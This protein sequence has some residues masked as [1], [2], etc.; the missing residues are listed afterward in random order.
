MTGKKK[1]IFFTLST[2]AVYR[3]LLFFPGSVYDRL[4]RIV[5]ERDDLCIVFLVPEKDF[6]KYAVLFGEDIADRMLLQ[7]VSV[8]YPRTFLEKAFYFFY[9]YLIYTGTTKQLATL[10]VRPEEP[11]AGGVL[12]QYLAPVKFL[13]ANTF[14]RW[15]TLREYIVP[16]LYL[17]IFRSRPFLELFSKYNPDLVFISHLYGRLDTELLAEAKRQRTPAIGMVANWDHLDKYYLPFKT[18]KLLVQSEQLKNFAVRFQHYP[19]ERAVL[20]GYPYFDFI[21]NGSYA[22]PR[23]ETLKDLGFPPDSKYILYVSGSAYCPDEPDIIET[24]LQWMAEGRFGGEVRLVIRP[25]LGGRAKDREFDEEKYN[26]FENH[27][28]ATFYRKE[29]WGD[30]DKSIQFMNIIRHAASIISIYSTIVIEAAVL[31]RPLVGIG[32][33]GYK[34]RSLQKSINRFAMREHFRDVLESGGLRTAHSFDELFLILDSYLKNPSLD[35][36]GRERLRRRVCGSLN[37]GSSE[38]IISAILD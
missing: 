29:F 11:P 13:I 14:G 37:N 1:T 4:R 18:D 17:G 22:K 3:N 19:A 33:D 24:I 9:S 12:K 6:H 31:D 26:R 5:R 20:T 25:Y 30:M 15:D 28:L 32:F 10:G 8:S 36:E 34:K 35:S 7:P 38:R 16:W 23:E 27:P 21:S 2:T